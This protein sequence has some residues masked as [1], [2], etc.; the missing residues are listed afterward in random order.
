M[1]FMEKMASFLYIQMIR[2]NAKILKIR[3]TRKFSQYV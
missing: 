2:F 1:R 3:I